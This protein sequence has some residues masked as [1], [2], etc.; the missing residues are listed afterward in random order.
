MLCARELRSGREYRI[1]HDELW[2]LSA[3]PY[4]HGADSLF[5]S[6]NAPAELS[7]YLPLG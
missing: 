2:R 1:W 6:Y 7:A 3:P 4:P 5:V